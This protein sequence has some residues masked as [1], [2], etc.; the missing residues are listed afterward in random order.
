[1][2]VTSSD[3]RAVGSHTLEVLTCHGTDSGSDCTAFVYSEDET[4]HEDISILLRDLE[5]GDL[6]IDELLQLSSSKWR[7]W[8]YCREEKSSGTK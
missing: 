6:E 3:E 7:S 5:Y 4:A 2:Q 8:F 1:M